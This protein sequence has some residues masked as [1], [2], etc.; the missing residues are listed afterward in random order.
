MW[1]NGLSR[2]QDE[3]EPVV[4]AFR[5]CQHTHAVGVDVSK[6]AEAALHIAT[7]SNETHVDGAL[8]R[9]GSMLAS[10]VVL[11]CGVGELTCAMTPSPDTNQLFSELHAAKQALLEAQAV[12]ST[13]AAALSKAARAVDVAQQHKASLQRSLS[14]VVKTIGALQGTLVQLQVRS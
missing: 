4:D 9:P 11:A 7:A 2:L 3:L 13:H 5:Q 6:D 1:V 10:D 12:V 8:L 14:R